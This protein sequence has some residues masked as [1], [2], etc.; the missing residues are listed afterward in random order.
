MTLVAGFRHTACP[1]F[2]P[3]HITSFAERS[4]VF[5]NAHAAAPLCSP[6]RASLF[7]GITPYRNGVQGLVHHAWRYRDDVLTAPERIRPFGYRSALIG[8]QHENVDP[9]VLGFDEVPGQGFLPRAHQVVDATAGWLSALPDRE[10]RAPLFLTVGTWEV[11]RPWPEEDYV[12]TDP[13]HVDVPT[14]LPDNDDTRRDIAAFYGSI[15]QFDDAFGRLIDAIDAALPSENTMIIFTTDHGAAF[16]RA[17]ST[18][19]NAGTGVAFIVRPPTGWNVPAGRVKEIV[20]H[21]DLVPTLLDL[22]GGTTDDWLE[23]R[24]LLPVLTEHRG[25]AERIVFT[26]KSYHD[27]Y[28]PKRAARTLDYLYVRNYAP[29]PLLELAADLEGSPTR[30]GMGDAHLAPRPPEELYDRRVDPE[31]LINVADDPEYSAVRHEYADRLNA[32]LAATGDPVEHEKVS[33]PPPRTRNV[34]GLVPLPA[35]R[36]DQVDLSVSPSSRPETEQR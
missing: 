16:P 12:P 8:L 13:A 2:P 20:S 1:T 24:S 34:D 35:V 6:A 30:A 22:A 9:T 18:L 36:A 23:G 15:A 11:H 7:T 21:L 32:W 33:P 5:E 25:E 10:D 14:Y 4:I 17:K 29:G 28:D 27:G 19:Y 26:A 31:E 3:P